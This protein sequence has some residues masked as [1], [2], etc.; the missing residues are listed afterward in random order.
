[1]ALQLLS[2]PADPAATT[3][4]HD[5]HLLVDGMPVHLRLIEPGD[6]EREIE[7]VAGLSPRTGYQR[8]MSARKPTLAELQRWTAIDREHEGAVV[9]T[10]IVDDREQQIAVARY[11]I[12]GPDGQADFAMVITDAWQGKGLGAHLLL[13]LVDLARLSGVWRLVG[14]TLS[15]NRK[16]LNLARR[17]GFRPR[18]QAGSAIITELTMDLNAAPELVH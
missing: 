9:A 5:L 1:M 16:M 15:E 14:T 4:W 17:L 8:L 12:D 6:L 7:F 10:A 3:P 13:A 2:L 18:R 11:V